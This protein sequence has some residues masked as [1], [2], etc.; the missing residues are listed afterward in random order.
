[1]AGLD[2]AIHART[3]HKQTTPAPLPKEDK[4]DTRQ[5]TRAARMSGPDPDQAVWRAFDAGWYRS[6]YPMVEDLLR[7]DPSRQPED[8]Y[9][10]QG[11]AL[12]HAPNPYFSESWYLRRYPSVRA[13]VRAGAFASGFDHFCRG[14]YLGLSP[15]WLFDPACYREQYQRARGR[16]FDPAAE[17]DPYDHFLRVGQYEGLSGHW[18]FEPGVYTALAPYDVFCRIMVDGPF[19]T[20]LL[21]IYSRGA[22]PTVSNLFDPGWY[23][24]RYPGVAAEIGA[25]RWTCALHHYLVNDDPGAFDP[26][27]RFSDHAYRTMSL[28]VAAA[29][30]DGAF[31]NG[32]EHFLH[33]GRTEGRPFSA[34]GIDPNAPEPSGVVASTSGFPLRTRVFREVTFCPFVRNKENPRAGHLLCVES[35]WKVHRGLQPLLGFHGTWYGCRAARSRARSS[36]AAFFWITS[37]TCCSTASHNLWFLRQRPDL[38]VLWHWIDHT[39]PHDLWPTWLDQIWRMLGLDQLQ[40]HRIVAPIRVER[41]ILAGSRNAGT[42]RIARAAGSRPRRAALHQ[43]LDR[44]PGLAVAPRGSEAVSAGSRRRKSWRPCW[45]HAD[46]A[47]VRPETQPLEDQVDIFATAGVVAGVIGSAFHSVVLSANPRAKLI[48]VCRPG[49]P[50]D[51]YNAVARAR[52]LRQYYVVPDLRP[53]TA[54]GPGATFDLAN[55]QRLADQVCALAD[56]TD[57]A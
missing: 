21:H 19:T 57:T 24:A 36:T 54:F 7:A 41:V 23:L 16:P 30:R 25:G 51:Y 50:H 44:Q 47:I 40:H 45:P 37:G 39:V 10:A 13:E 4:P 29:V 48:L 27:A 17:G 55:P 22:E 56:R 6:A 14:G 11:R 9:A 32:F 1:M 43:A 42:T 3:L 38:P 18:L 26:S 28:D 8:I 52:G 33:H 46:W 53:H 2:P 35:R 5:Q 34:S 49:L 12:E 31:R 20:F 15:H